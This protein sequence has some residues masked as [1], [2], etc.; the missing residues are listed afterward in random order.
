MRG[1]HVLLID[2]HP[3]EVLRHLGDAPV[4]VGVFQGLGDALVLVVGEHQAVGAEAV[5]T[6]FG[7]GGGG[8]QGLQ[9]L[10]DVEIGEAAGDGVRDHGGGVVADHAV[11]LVAPEFPDGQFA[12]L[13]VDGQEGLEEVVAPLGLEL[14]EERVLGAEGVPEREHGVALPALGAV[15][16]AVHSAVF[17]VRVGVQRGVD[18]RVVEGGVEAPEVLLVAPGAGE[19]AQVGLPGGLGPGAQFFERGTLLGL[20]VQPG[21]LL[22]HG[23]DAHADAHRAR[24]AREGEHGLASPVQEFAAGGRGEVHPE[25]DVLP[26]RPAGGLAPAA[27]GVAPLGGDA[28][29]VQHVPVGQVEGDLRAGPG[30]EG[31]FVPADAPAGGQP[32]L[33]LRVLQED[34]VVAGGGLFPLVGEGRRPG[35]REQQDVAEVVAAGTAQVRMA[36]AVD[37][38]VAVVIAAAA[39]PVARL[40]ARVGTELHHPEGRDGAGEGVAVFVGADEGIDVLDQARICGEVPGQARDEEQQGE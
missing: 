35:A 4:V 19:F 20:E 14:P 40:G 30:G 29:V 21:V 34:F 13:V 9:R 2:V 12:G 3:A 10:R 36:E 26:V 33:H 15:Y 1:G 38:M 37:D 8:D 16:P 7:P 32:D 28:P 17:A 18:A 11:G 27:H 23:G 25:I 24:P 6:E 31:V 39:V 5:Q 22:A